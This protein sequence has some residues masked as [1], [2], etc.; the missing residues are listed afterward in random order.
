MNIEEYLLYYKFNYVI[1]IILISFAFSMII[2]NPLKVTSDHTLG[3][4]NRNSVVDVEY[5]LYKECG[6]PFSSD[7]SREWPDRAS[8]CVYQE[9]N[10]GESDP[11]I[12]VYLGIGST[13][14]EDIK[15]D[16]PNVN[17]NYYEDWKT[18]MIGLSVNQFKTFIVLSEN[19]P[20]RNG[21]LF[22]EIMITKLYNPELVPHETESSSSSQSNNQPTT[23]G[24]DN[25][26]LIVAVLAISGG[27]IGSF[28]YI[29]LNNSPSIKTEEL[30]TSN[31]ARE[32][33]RIQSL[34][35]ILNERE[36]SASKQSKSSI[37]R[38]KNSKPRRR[39]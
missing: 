29:R 5:N 13:V 19:Q 16:Y 24:E 31:K 33:E 11:F 28:A 27:I 32:N 38:K 30:L 14:P 34:K 23:S 22:F 10:M 6:T 36:S 17:P 3:Y 9:G 25:S 15:K 21:D 35:N 1:K 20:D 18:A 39:R 12:Q 26:I 8:G 2:F 7:Q 37:G 4:A